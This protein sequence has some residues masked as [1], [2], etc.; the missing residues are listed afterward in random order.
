MYWWNIQ[1]QILTH[2]TAWQKRKMI[3]ENLKRTRSQMWKSDPD[4]FRRNSFGIYNTLSKSEAQSLKLIM[5]KTKLSDDQERKKK[6]AC[7][8]YIIFQFNILLEEK[9][10]TKKVLVWVCSKDAVYQLFWYRQLKAS[11]QCE[12][13]KDGS[14]W[15]VT[16]G[17]LLSFQPNKTELGKTDFDCGFQRHQHLLDLKE[18]ELRE[19]QLCT[20]WWLALAH[21]Q[22]F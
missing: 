15:L 11:I 19:S 5:K 16:I 18:V 6:K 1:K 20:E 12:T 9:K 4:S 17:I 10:R 8:W 13:E 2:L 14:K 21:L 7:G 22:K 3:K